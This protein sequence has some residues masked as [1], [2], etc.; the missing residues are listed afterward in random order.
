M[1]NE[2]SQ[3]NGPAGMRSELSGMRRSSPLGPRLSVIERSHWRDFATAVILD[4]RHF[5]VR[6]ARTSRRRRDLSHLRYRGII[7]DLEP[8]ARARG[9]LAEASVTPRRRQNRGS[10]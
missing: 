3:N 9:Q 6:D 4:R 8:R 1:R 10:R 7:T 2:S 5:G